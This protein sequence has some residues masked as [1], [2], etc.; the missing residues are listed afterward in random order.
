MRTLLLVVLL[1]AGG[2]GYWYWNA[3]QEARYT[4]TTV[5]VSRGQL[6]TSVTATGTL[7]PEELVDVGAQIAGMVKEI[8]QDPAGSGRPISHG[9]QVEAGTVLARLDDVLFKTRVNQARANLQRAQ[10]EREQAEA[11]RRQADRDLDRAGR[12]R[13]GRAIS[14]Q[15]HETTLSNQETARANLA[16]AVSNVAQA[17]ANLEEAIANLGY[18]TIC[19]PVRGVV[20]DR[21][22]NV[23][24]TVVASLNTPSLFLIARDLSRMQIWASVNEADINRIRIG[25]RAR[26]TVSGLPGD[27]FVG[28]VAEI[29]LNAS[30]VSN[31]VIYTVTVAV[32]NSSGRLLPYQT[33]RVQFEIDRRQ[34]VL[35]VPN[36]ALRWI[37]RPEQVVPEARADLAAGGDD[38]RDAHGIVWVVSGDFVRPLR[39]RL[40]ITDGTRTEISSAELEAGS[41]VVIRAS[42]RKAGRTGNG[43]LV[44]SFDEP[45]SR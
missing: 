1:A 37:P 13:L 24:Q 30:M 27:E 15:E 44:P 20:I 33:A 16:A 19:S 39:V 25:Q 32:D 31:V 12:L 45:T 43:L 42:E 9:T 18:T 38:K 11:R 23:G 7:E 10:A 40:G 3:G 41:E 22:V 36:A 34:D 6:V 35:L 17:R 21:R 8:G 29:R 28:Q 2:G 14:T 4:C 26:F 5:P